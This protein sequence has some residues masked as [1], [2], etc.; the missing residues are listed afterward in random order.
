M[1]RVTFTQLA[2]RYSSLA[3]AV[4]RAFWLPFMNRITTLFPVGVAALLGPFALA[5]TVCAQSWI[6]RSAPN[7]DWWSVASSADGSNLVAAAR[8]PSAPYAGPIYMSTNSGAT[9]ISNSLSLQTW[10]CV[11]SSADGTKLAAADGGTGGRIYLSTNA[12]DTW[13]A[14]G[15]PG[16]SWNSVA[17]SADGSNL[18]AATSSRAVYTSSDSGTTWISNSLPAGN[19]VAS[20]ADGTKLAVAGSMSGAIYTSINSGIAW[21]SNYT[22]ASFFACLASSADGSKLAFGIGG[23]GG[24]IYTSTDSGATWASNSVPRDVWTSIAMSADGRKL[25]AGGYSWIYTSTNSGA[26][27][28]S[29]NVPIVNWQCVASSADG[30]KLVALVSGGGIY[31]WQST[32]RPQLSLSPSGTNMAL[33]W[34]VPSG[35]FLLQHSPDLGEAS[36]TTLTNTPLLNL[37]NLQDQVLLSP[38]SDQGFYRLISQ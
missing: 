28:V 21:A 23:N 4:L 34:L 8:G 32:P 24:P 9:W 22:G 13:A 26:T 27:W 38:A 17:M 36:W 37:T 33:S 6:Q 35:N 12:G 1:N 25:V 20:S 10:S 18:L 3:A 29:N 7:K 16:Q 14:S 2:A 15:A 5:T 30:G 19:A 11:A 31:T